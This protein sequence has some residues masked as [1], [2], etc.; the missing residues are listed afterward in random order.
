MTNSVPQENQASS[1]TCPFSGAYSEGR[2][3]AGK[4][5]MGCPVSANA[6][7]FDAF[8]GPYQVDPAEAL[9]WSRAQ[10]PVFY[11]PKLGY[12]VVSRYEQVKA[13]FRDN[14]TFSPSI[15]LEKVTPNSP[16]A[17][18]VLARYNYGMDRTLV[19]EDEP[20]HMERRRAPH[21]VFRARGPCSSRTDGEKARPRVR[22]PPSS[23]RARP[24]WSTR[25]C[26]RS[27]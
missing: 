2:R 23:T 14:V 10:E 6:S 16:E 22:G 13:V 15:A 4:D 25:C 8:E 21:A 26:G 18:A 12:W 11:S 5:S 3:N 7:A 27:R 24:T 1:D 20:M 19:N 9:R 17:D